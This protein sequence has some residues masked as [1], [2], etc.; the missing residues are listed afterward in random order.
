MLA[1]HTNEK[2]H[3]MLAGCNNISDTDGIGGRLQAEQAESLG[4][5]PQAFHN[6]VDD[7]RER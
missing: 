5:C 1:S 3:Y 4:A 6:K 7:R 2:P